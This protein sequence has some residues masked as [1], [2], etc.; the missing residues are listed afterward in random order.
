MNKLKLNVEMLKV[1]SF[2]THAGS[3][4][5]G[6]VHGNS[7]SFTGCNQSVVTLCGTCAGNIGCPPSEAAQENN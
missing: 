2:E 7:V 4:M 1:V 6:T 5:H 3:A